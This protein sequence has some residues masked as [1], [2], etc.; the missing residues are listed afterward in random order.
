M[1]D[2]SRRDVLKGTGI[3][4]T[5]AAIAT[6][7]ATADHNSA[8]RS[9]DHRNLS[10]Y[11]HCDETRTNPDYSAFH[12][13]AIDGIEDF[14][15]WID[16]YMYYTDDS[17]VLDYSETPT[18]RHT[19]SK[20]ESPEDVYA[21]TEDFRKRPD[22]IHIGLISDSDA[23]LGQSEGKLYEWNDPYYDADDWNDPKPGEGVYCIVNATHAP[24]TSYDYGYNTAIHEIAHGMT[25]NPQQTLGWRA[26]HAMGVPNSESDSGYEPTVMATGYSHIAN[27]DD[28]EMPDEDC[29]GNSWGYSY[30]SVP[31]PV[32]RLTG[33]TVNK[34]SEYHAGNIGAGPRTDKF[35]V[36]VKDNENPWL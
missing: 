4:A 32:P 33:C 19:D 26:D 34:L 25:Y 1:S 11:I 8:N 28:D 15:E 12:R 9:E 23:P 10:F 31:D 21:V 5:S 22:A 13:G 17:I 24:D 20:F 30:I 35:Y 29:E 14:A 36:S 18:M 27:S 3:A 16:S 6:G 2:F 7:V